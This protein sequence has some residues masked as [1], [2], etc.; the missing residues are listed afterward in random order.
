MT[1]AGLCGLVFPFFAHAGSM[2]SCQQQSQNAPKNC[3]SA[4]RQVEAFKASLSSGASRAASGRGMSD[5]GFNLSSITKDGASADLQAAQYCQQQRTQCDSACSGVEYP[6]Q[7][8]ANGLKQKCDASIDQ[9]IQKAQ[10]SAQN[11]DG[12]SK[13]SSETGKQSQQGMPQM[14][15]PK[16]SDDPGAASDPQSL[17]SD[18][19][20]S[21]D[22]SADSGKK[23]DSGASTAGFQ[24]VSC[25]SDTAY[26]FDRCSS[27]LA[28][29]CNGKFSSST[30]CENFSRRYCDVSARSR[31]S[32]ASSGAMPAGQGNGSDYCM[33]YLGSD[34]CSKTPGAEACPSC[35]HRAPS[36][37]QT[38]P[39][40]CMNDPAYSN[41]AVAQAVNSGTY[42]FAGA[43]G[44]SAS[45]LAS[46]SAGSGNAKAG[47]AAYGAEAEG[48]ARHGSLDAGGGGG[49]GYAG[50]ASAGSSE[51]GSSEN[52]SFL[53]G[54]KR[55]PSAAGEAGVRT[56]SVTDV[57]HREQ[58]VFAISSEVLLKRCLNGRLLH[59]ESKK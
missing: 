1:L 42:S 9:N 49:G 41:P 50:S 26:L 55:K 16:G 37:G 33:A 44:A 39:A 35:S 54:G 24:G 30:V 10:Q 8:A 15:P 3:E 38:L 36:A 13:D 58:N 53:L 52:E 21:T 4:M 32:Q 48:S 14:Q 40:V 2:A 11:L 29:R 46:A 27:E 19:S 5:N 20:S 23:T 7:P 59:C 6:H 25:A 47:A 56:A 34:F 51:G 17:A 57:A 12:D 22:S 18:S 45:G 43:S 31:G 28:S